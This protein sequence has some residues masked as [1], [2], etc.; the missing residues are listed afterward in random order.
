[1]RVLCVGDSLG[2]PREDCPYEETWFYKLEE[3]FSSHT[4]I[5]YFIR[6]MIIRDALNRYETYFQYYASDIVII[7]AGIVDCAPRYIQEKK[8]SVKAL[9]LVLKKL[10]LE[11]FFW[12]VIKRRGRKKDCVF[13]DFDT[14]Y[15]TY[16]LLVSKLLSGGVKK[17][18]LIKIGHATD[19]VLLKNPFIN[20]NV[21]KYNK[22]I[23]QI[24]A[25]HNDEVKA[26]DPL[27]NVCE[28]DFVD[29][30]HCSPIGMRKVFEELKNELLT[31]GLTR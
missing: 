16:D 19:T 21:D 12:R 6:G 5:D 24:C 18:F 2:L 13:T 26:L 23:E 15:N 29:G 8:T 9:L 30:Y 28:K 25:N 1:M 27:F 17:I 11:N 7:Q 22:A 3:Y 4:F 10:R 14:F 20:N 31:Y